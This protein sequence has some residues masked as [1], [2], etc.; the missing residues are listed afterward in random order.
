MRQLLPNLRFAVRAMGTRPLFSLVVVAT[1]ALGI[2]ANAAMFTVVEGVL[3]E[4]LPY[5]D[6]DRLVWVWGITSDGDRNTIS[7]ESYQDYQA[8][9][10]SFRDLAAT[11]V[12]PD[13]YV[14]TGGDA[15]QVAL[16][17]MVS[18]NLFRALG[19]E[20]LLGR[21]FA[22]DDE[23]EGSPDVVV[24]S[25]RLWHARYGGA[26]DVVG[27]TIV[28]DGTPRTI[29]GVM[30]P[31]A[32]LF[33]RTDIWEP[34]R[35]SAGMATGR[36]NNNFRLFG[37][38]EDGV[39][40]AQA[41]AEMKALAAGVAE[42]FPDLFEGWTVDLVPLHEVFVGDVRATL[43]LLMGAVG[44]VLLVTSANLAALM[45]AR[46]E[47][48]RREVAVR[49]AM[50]A[51]RARVV[52]QLLTE[53]VVMAV[54]G[55]LLGLGL[56]RALL[57][58]LGTVGPGSLPRLET[59]GLDAGTLLFTAVVSLGTGILFGLAPAVQ[60]P[61][62]PLVETLK[63]AG[64]PRGRRSAH[65]AQSVLVVAQVAFSVVLLAGA[66]LLLR[67]FQ[68]LRSVE[69]G[70]DPVGVLTAQVRLPASEYG[71]ERPPSVF[72]EAALER[73]RALPGVESA[74]VAGGLPVIGGTGPWNYAW[75]EGHEPATPAERRG[76]TRRLA[77]PGYFE[78][79]GIPLE[80][81]GFT[82]ADREDGLPVVIISRS[83]AE[84]FFPGEN[85]IGQGLI[86]WGTRFE[87]V[88]V[89]GDVMVGGPGG[90]YAPI[91]Y[92][93]L[94]QMPFATSGTLVLRTAIDPE[95]LA[96]EL[97]K[98][99]RVVDP[100]APIEEIR[101]MASLVEG[102]LA[103][104]RLRTLVLGAFAAA[105]LLLS[106]LGLYGV[107]ATFVGQRTH[108]MGV[109]MALGA[110]H[111]QVMT[112]VLT[113]GLALAGTGL[114]LGVALALAAARLLR[115]MLFGIGALDLRAFAWTIAVLALAALAAALAPALR[116][117]RVDPVESLRAE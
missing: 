29:V 82:T 6:A 23:Q 7:A 22:P 17:T 62:L 14:L 19:T 93:A 41:S 32:D 43:W 57:A 31:E 105:A 16:G 26:P 117:T 89:A 24:L 15:P 27:G 49:L 59:V 83:A 25:N 66:G 79:F 36:G 91:F 108:E 21:G 115:G 61:R 51:S 100:N 110:G 103:T 63:E 77:A 116:A 54:A 69:L 97:R 114:A 5:P 84:T 65:R 20:P 47:D 46:S 109:R 78:T 38:L 4:P 113:R 1:L 12:F 58:G 30:P 88:G 72:W 39:T 80:G 71:P 106:A 13:E 68:E 81:R 55:G 107:L 87:V 28:L 10:R 102:T 35:M 33:G 85:P 18:W 44:L 96:L 104:D 75:A 34:L 111:G 8:S 3:L 76:A 90:D 64:G 2:G 60:V 56:A 45:L 92:L 37:R 98:A 42:R 112:T 9:S 70:I 50:G 11:S 94:H 40:L 99:L 53:S 52:E 95:A 48:R 67:S 101:T 73:V 74:T 86:V